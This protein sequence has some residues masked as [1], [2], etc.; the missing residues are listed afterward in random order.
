MNVVIF[1]DLK[2]KVYMFSLVLDA[3]NVVVNVGQLFSASPNELEKL[4]RFSS[5]H[6]VP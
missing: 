4:F 1:E 6:I 3:N 2:M 5:Q